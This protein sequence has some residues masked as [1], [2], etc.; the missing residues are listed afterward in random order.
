MWGGLA[1]FHLAWQSVAEVTYVNKRVSPR[2]CSVLVGG[3]SY[4][5]SRHVI[6]AFRNVADT[7]CHVLCF[8]WVACKEGAQGPLETS[9][10]VYRV[11][12]RL[13]D[14]QHENPGTRMCGA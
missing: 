3:E 10:G 5:H 12:R 6:G 11:L 9:H 13:S 14:K 2:R 4:G 7:V 1:L 8:G